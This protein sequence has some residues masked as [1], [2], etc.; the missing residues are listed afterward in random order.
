M[1]ASLCVSVLTGVFVVRVF[2]GMSVC[3]C[4]CVCGD[5]TEDRAMFPQGFPF[6]EI[7]DSGIR[8]VLHKVTRLQY[9]G[10]YSNIVY[11]CRLQFVSVFI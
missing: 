9:D 10:L 11:N 8:P 6:K 5:W 4:V 1:Y 3:V 7:K 2:C